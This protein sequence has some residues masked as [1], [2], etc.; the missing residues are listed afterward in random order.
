MSIRDTVKTAKRIKHDN[1]NDEIDRL[2]QTAR[3]EM[4]RV[5][6]DDTKANSSDDSLITQ[7]I[8][9][10]CLKEMA[11]TEENSDRYGLS[12]SIQID[13]LRKSEDYRCTT[14]SSNSE[15]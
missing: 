7:A 1:L 14:T 13:N 2:I 12:W 9:T 4:I 8:V 10:F 5:G 3:D 11:G 15:P 6:I